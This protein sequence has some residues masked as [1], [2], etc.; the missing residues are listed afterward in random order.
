M[1]S[2]CNSVT[3]TQ[4]LYSVLFSTSPDASHMVVQL[5]N[6][7]LWFRVDV[8]RWCTTITGCFEPSQQ[9]PPVGRSAVVAKSLPISFRPPAFLL[10]S[11]PEPTRGSFYCLPNP[12]P[13]Y[14]PSMLMR[15]VSISFVSSA[16]QN[17]IN[18]WGAILHFKFPTLGHSG[19]ILQ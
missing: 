5:D 12:A 17:N 10:T 16:L 13:N 4:S 3:V 9:H 8:I 11:M 14:T 6:C 19:E 15:H 7:G 1:Y 2:H 18:F